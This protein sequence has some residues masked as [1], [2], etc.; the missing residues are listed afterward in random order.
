MVQTL[1]K[2]GRYIKRW[3]NPKF[4]EASL[5]KGEKEGAASHFMAHFKWKA[6]LKGSAQA[7]NISKG[8]ARVKTLI[9]VGAWGPTFKP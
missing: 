1:N 9:L 3:L 8:G 5:K 4:R 6:L 2:R 7:K